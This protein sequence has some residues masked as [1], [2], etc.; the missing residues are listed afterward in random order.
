MKLIV[1]NPPKEVEGFVHRAEKHLEKSGE[2][3]GDIK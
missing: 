1:F 3:A 2:H